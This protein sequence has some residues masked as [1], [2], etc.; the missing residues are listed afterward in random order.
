LKNVWTED[1]TIVVRNSRELAQRMADAM[2]KEVCIYE[3]PHGYH[4]SMAVIW[5]QKKNRLGY[6]LLEKVGPDQGIC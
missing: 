3:S 1:Q 4:V 6:I 5:E 2:D